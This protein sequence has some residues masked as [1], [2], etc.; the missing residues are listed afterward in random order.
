M[1]A[2]RSVDRSAF[3]PAVRELVDRLT[4]AW[5]GPRRSDVFASRGGGPDPLSDDGIQPLAT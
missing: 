2:S 5:C 4:S 1:T 3:L